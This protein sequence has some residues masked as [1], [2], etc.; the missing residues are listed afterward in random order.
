M[1]EKLTTF[2]EV[3]EAL[4]GQSSLAE[5]TGRKP[6]AVS[7]WR[8]QTGRFPSRIYPVI[9][10]ALNERGLSAAYSLFGFELPRR[11]KKRAG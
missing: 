7:N 6:T 1:R 11:R 3:A 9:E 10:G 2:D 5:L 4:G 8:C